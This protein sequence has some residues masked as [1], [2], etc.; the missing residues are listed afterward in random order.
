LSHLNL[1][2][3]VLSSKIG[4]VKKTHFRLNFRAKKKSS[5]GG[6]WTGH[7]QAS[8][9]GFFFARKLSLKWVF[10]TPQS[11]KSCSIRQGKLSVRKKVNFEIEVAD[12]IFCIQWSI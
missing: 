10:L 12:W 5:H 9:R 4:G 8:M 2:I 1:E 6:L 3:R 7:P 11:A